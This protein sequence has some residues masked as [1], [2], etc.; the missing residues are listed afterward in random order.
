MIN[1]SE[2]FKERLRTIEGSKNFP[3]F[4]ELAEATWEAN[5]SSR[6]PNEKAFYLE[7]F[8]LNK[9]LI[10]REHKLQPALL[11]WKNWVEWREKFGPHRI[12]PQ[13][14]ANEFNIRK[15]FWHGEDKKRHPLVHV[16]IL[17]TDPDA[18]PKEVVKF[19]IYNIEKGI[20]E[21]EKRGQNE[22]VVIVDMKGFSRKLMAN[23]VTNT[24][25]ELLTLIQSYYP[26]RLH[27]LYLVNTTWLFKLLY[28]ILKPF[29]DTKTR[30]KLSFPSH[31]EEL[32]KDI[33]ADNL[34]QDLQGT[35]IEPTLSIE[36]EETDW[37][38]RFSQYNS[39]TS[40]KNKVD[41]SEKKEIEDIVVMKKVRSVEKLDMVLITTNTDRC[42]TEEIQSS[43]ILDYVADEHYTVKRLPYIKAL[44]IVNPF[45]TPR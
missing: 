7:K 26:E 30:N 17:R 12:T 11:M 6:F 31:L 43:R 18:D 19:G 13:E 10:A 5:F 15:T 37:E 14:C 32:K 20:K 22:I 28:T 3:E 34:L 38:L 35:A 40:K 33:T 42:M 4:F 24:M 39:T 36:E 8:Q 44:K 29:I 27:K 25:K 16:K 21:A 41:D 45:L 23:K 9:F 1:Q 2:F